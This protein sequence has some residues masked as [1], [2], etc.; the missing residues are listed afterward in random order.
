MFAEK[1]AEGSRPIALQR[2]FSADLEAG[3]VKELCKGDSLFHLNA[4]GALMDV[5]S[6]CGA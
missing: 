5:W 4:V 3:E 2:I 1:K 6:G